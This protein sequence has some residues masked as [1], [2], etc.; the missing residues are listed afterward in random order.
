M[1]HHQHQYI[2]VALAPVQIAWLHFYILIKICLY[3]WLVL[4]AGG[5]S[6]TF[7]QEKR[8]PMNNYIF[9]EKMSIVQH[10]KSYLLCVC[11]YNDNTDSLYEGDI[12]PCIHSNST[13]DCDLGLLL[14]RDRPPSGPVREVASSIKKRSIL[15]LQGIES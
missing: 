1:Q 15:S 12:L 2:S 7:S 11:G 9:H 3:N 5:T 14:L 6:N 10:C 4:I 13:C 8:G